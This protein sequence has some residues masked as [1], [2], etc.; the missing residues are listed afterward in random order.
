MGS[1][2][3]RLAAGVGAVAGA[4]GY[5]ALSAGGSATGASVSAGSAARC[6]ACSSRAQRLPLGGLADRSIA[7][8]GRRRGCQR[9]GELGGRLGGGDL[10][11]GRRR[12][13][14]R[15]PSR[16]RARGQRRMAGV[17]WRERASAVR[18]RRASGRAG[19]GVATPASS[20]RLAALAWPLVPCLG[21][22]LRLT[23]LPA[24]GD[25]PLALL[26]GACPLLL[27][28]AARFSSRWRRRRAQN[29]SFCGGG[30]RP[31]PAP[32]AAGAGAAPGPPAAGR[33]PWAVRSAPP[34][35]RAWPRGAPA[36]PAFRRRAA[37]RVAGAQPP[38]R[39]R[40]SARFRCASAR[41]AW[42]C[43]ALV[44]PARA[45]PPGRR[46]RRRSGGRDRGRQGWLR[47]S[48]PGAAAAL[49]APRRWRPGRSRGRLR[50]LVGARLRRLRLRSRRAAGWLSSPE[51]LFLRCNLNE[52]IRSYGF[53]ARARPSVPPARR[54]IACAISFRASGGASRARPRGARRDRGSRAAGRA[55]PCREPA[56]ARPWRAG[57]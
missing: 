3:L 17:G 16:A 10:R 23:T 32:V 49:A 36:W 38:C 52:R 40:A 12:A 56:P 39:A 25:R 34:R 19:G 18:A 6:S 31:G 2:G 47:A 13:R 22:L 8:R 29:D 11:L 30:A 21:L 57:P 46:H 28:E 15:A 41:L 37:R 55:A 33:R 53:T 45:A 7:A 54:R 9:A 35:R 42:R 4:G 5:P 48:R 20:P 50:R 43:C 1:L 24:L 27:A 44:A 51:A 14:A 26:L